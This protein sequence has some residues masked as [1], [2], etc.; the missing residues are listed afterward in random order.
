[1][2]EESERARGLEMSMELL[3]DCSVLLVFGNV[4][5][6]GMQREI[7]WW[8]ENKEYHPIQYLSRAKVSK[9]KA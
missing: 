5:T 7:E 6:A 1:M 9:K 8:K 3:K 2:D 4:M